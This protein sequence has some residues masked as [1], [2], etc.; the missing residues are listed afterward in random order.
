MARH[1]E[2]GERRDERAEAARVSPVKIQQSLKGISYPA[3]KDDLVET[4]R[5]ND[6]PDMVMKVLERL[7]DREY[8]GP[9]EVM[10][11]TKPLI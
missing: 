11:E 2:R 8:D 6:A 5:G 3:K 10:K 9:Q 4:A 7:P 1:E